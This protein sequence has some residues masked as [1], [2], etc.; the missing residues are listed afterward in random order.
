MQTFTVCTHSHILLCEHHKPPEY[1]SYWIHNKQQQHETGQSL[2]YNPAASVSLWFS[3]SE[4]LFLSWTNLASVGLGVSY[5][6]SKFSCLIDSPNNGFLSVCPNA[7]EKHIKMLIIPNYFVY[8]YSTIELFSVLFWKST[9][10][11]QCRWSWPQYLYLN[12]DWFFH[13]KYFHRKCQISNPAQ[14][15]PDLPFSFQWNEPLTGQRHW[16]DQ[17]HRT[18]A[19]AVISAV[20]E[21]SRKLAV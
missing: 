16:S 13:R 17:S 11:E 5:A 4:M 2:F 21:A 14:I 9:K 20:K 18:V 1:P 19:A 10:T 7:R 15:K 6:W 3:K 12:S 8:W